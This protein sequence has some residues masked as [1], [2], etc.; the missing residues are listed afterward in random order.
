MTD[1]KLTVIEGQIISAQAMMPAM[2]MTAAKER[3]DAMV[4]FVREIMEVGRDYGIVPG[5]GSKP[6]LFKPGAEKLKTFFGLTNRF[7]PVEREQDWTGKSHNGEPFFYYWYSCQLWR[8]DILISEA[9]GSC[10][11]WESKY[12]YRKAERVC[13]NCGQSAIIKGKTEYGGGW[14]CWSKKGGC[15][16]KFRDGDTQIESQD[17]GRV[18]NP[19][20]ADQVNTILKMAQKRALVAAILIGVNAS[21]F[22]TQDLE[23]FESGEEEPP[24]TTK[25]GLLRRASENHAGPEDTDPP[26]TAQDQRDNA[27][28][29]ATQPKGLYKPEPAPESNTDKPAQQQPQDRSD[30]AAFFAAMRDVGLTDKNVVH[31][32][33]GVASMKDFPSQGIQMTINVLRMA[34]AHKGL[35]VAQ[36]LEALM[37]P[38]LLAWYKG[39]ADFATAQGLVEAWIK[40]HQESREGEAAHPEPAVEDLAF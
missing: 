29:A 34:I 32:L 24:V 38:D 28:P 16:A 5:T 3:R 20:V 25:R 19:D 7:V 9:D 4:A 27:P 8:G 2:H 36:T 10:N 6:A 35:T 40:D 26:P 14:L 13:P 37:V 18:S 12:R 39:G 31:R 15:G 30:F 1:N 21:E 22:F 33:Y 23:D 11:S 17:T